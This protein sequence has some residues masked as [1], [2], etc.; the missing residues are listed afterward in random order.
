MEMEHVPDIELIER[1]YS[2]RTFADQQHLIIGMPLSGDAAMKYIGAQLWTPVFLM[3]EP[4]V[5][6]ITE[7]IRKALLEITLSRFF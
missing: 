4:I 2:E 5:G 6:R 1:F 7:Y 3:A